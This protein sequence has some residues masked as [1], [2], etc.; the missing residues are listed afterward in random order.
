M[1]YLKVFTDFAK[2]IE[3]LND[4]EVGRLFRAMLLYAESETESDLK[5]NER[6]VWGTAKKSIDNQAESYKTRC[7][8]NRIIATNRYESLRNATKKHE[9]YQ[10]KDKEKDKDKEYIKEKVI[11]KKNFEPPTLEEVKAYCIERGNDVDPKRFHDYYSAGDWKDGKGNP[12]K[13]WKQKLLT[14]EKQGNQ[15]KSSF[16]IDSIRR[17]VDAERRSQSLLIADADALDIL[18]SSTD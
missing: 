5:G 4:A 3:P 7:E 8:T 16:L 6:F 11:K 14:W 1:K 18:Q 10:D 9:S 17:D 2:D 13:N 15:S 12:V